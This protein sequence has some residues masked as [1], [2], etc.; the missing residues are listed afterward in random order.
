MVSV[1][2]SAYNGEKYIYYQVESILKQLDSLDELIIYDD[3]STDSTVP[4]LQTIHDSRI[5]LICGKRNIGFLKGFQIAIENA[6][7]DYIILSDQDDIWLK[8]KVLTIKSIFQTEKCDCIIHDAII[9]DENMNILSKSMFEFLGITTNPF[10]NF[11]HN[12]A[13][14]ACMAFKAEIV[15]CIL[16]FPSFAVYHDRWISVILSLCGKKIICISEPLIFYV[17]HDGTVTNFHRNNIISIVLDRIK[18][19]L[20]VLYRI[21]IFDLFKIIKM[22][23]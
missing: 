8:N 10:F 21:F 16:P 13:T 7:G 3:C 17:R 22:H 9:V 19:F 2:M 4:L 6:K 14:G 23:S 18:F 15:K 1:C 11:V 12:T 5:R 20:A